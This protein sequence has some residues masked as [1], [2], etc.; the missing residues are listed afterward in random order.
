MVVERGVIQFRERSQ[1]IRDYSGLRF[2][3]ITPT[4]IDIHIEYHNIAHVFAELK[5]GDAGVPV[6]QAT[7]LTRLCD[8]ITK[9]ALLI[10]AKHCTPIGQDIDAAAAEVVSYRYQRR[11][12]R[13]PKRVTVGELVTRFLQ[14]CEQKVSG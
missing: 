5:Y 13:P 2:G 1:Q 12:Y 6:G 7:A 3:N 4:D 10:F 9:P 11:D 8:D 14:R